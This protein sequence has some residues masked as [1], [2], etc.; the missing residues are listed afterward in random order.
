MRDSL[1]SK[2]AGTVRREDFAPLEHAFSDS[3]IAY[4]VKQSSL[5]LDLLSD[6]TSRGLPSRAEM[7]DAMM[8]AASAPDYDV[9]QIRPHRYG[10]I[11]KVSAAPQGMAPQEQQ[12]TRQEAQQAFPPEA[13]QQADQQG[14]A[15]LTGVDAPAVDP[16]AEKPEPVNKSGLYKVFEAGTGK[17][18][19]GYVIPGLFDPMAGAQTPMNLFTNGN[20]YAMTP[21]PMLGVLLAQ[22]PS[23]P[24]SDVIRGLGVFYKTENTAIMATVPYT[25]LGQVTTP[26]GETYYS[27]KDSA[28]QDVQI[29]IGQGLKRPVASGPGQVIM[30]DSFSFMALDNPIQIGAG[31]AGI[32]AGDPN[33]PAK[34]ASHDTLIRVRAWDDAVELSGGAVEKIGSGMHSHVDA[35]FWMAATG[36]PQQV[37]AEI[38]KISSS[39][40]RPVELFGVQKL[41]SKKD[42]LDAAR[43]KVAAAM[44]V[45][46]DL[47]A[48]QNLLIDAVMLSKE[49]DSG[50]V[51]A[52]T[53]D[54][55][56]SLN[57]INRENIDTFLDNLPQLE[58]AASKLAELNLA[59]DLGLSGIPGNVVTR[60]MSSL[61]T[62]ID[63]LNGLKQYEV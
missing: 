45:E 39:K 43:T 10:Y 29:T 32:S 12:I 16:L 53:V 18:F 48:P 61:E 33:Q 2:L 14:A 36:I 19:V 13:L 37:S 5:V 49:A 25:V 17:Q 15:T 55:V 63:R 26:A 11:L 41:S 60:A 4:H 34:M 52:K 54:A 28:G 31:Q 51:S 23:L 22:A 59:V 35:V 47:P 9:V 46:A 42:E 20:Q 3:T 21:E 62:V 57:F 8:K 1:C 38:I 58:D 27:A 6:V 56:L 44:S 40:G 30:P 50:N 24:S 7:A